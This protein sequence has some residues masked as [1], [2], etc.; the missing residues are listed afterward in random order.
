M[1]DTRTLVLIPARMAATRLPGKPL[2]DIAGLPMIVH[3]LRRAEAAQIG[4]VAVATDTPEIAAAVTS[5]GGEAVVT[6]ADHPTGSDRIYEAL[7]KLDPSGEAEIVVNLQ[8]DF[9]TILPE[10]IRDVLGPLADPAVDIATLAAEI[11]T[12]EES[13]NPNVV[14]AVGTPLSARKVKRAPPRLTATDRATIMSASMP[15]AARRWSVSSRCPPLSWSDRRNSSNCGRSRPG[16]G[17]T[18]RSST[19]C[20]AASI[21]RPT[22]KPPACYW[23]KPE[24]LVQG[25]P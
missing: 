19:P 21:R 4:R 16:C 6:R 10:N 11:H 14:K 18:S 9:P 3:V 7:C 2:L 24:R 15:I 25:A 17:S 23:Q 5:S 1:P 20:R 22:L 8:G 13:L 12:E